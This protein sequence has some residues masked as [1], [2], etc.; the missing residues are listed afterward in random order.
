MTRFLCF[1][2]TWL[3]S[4]SF[5]STAQTLRDDFSGYAAGSDSA[6]AWDAQSVGWEISDGACIG[7]SGVSVW[8]AAPFASA[9]TFT[10]DVTVLEQLKGDWLVAGIGLQA[11]E[12]NYWA[13]NLVAA[14]E[15]KQRRHTAELNESHAG[16]WLAAGTGNTRLPSLPGKGG[17]DWQLNQT[18]RFEISLTADAITAR[19][20]QGADELARFGFKLPA[21]T[22]AVRAGRPM[23]RASGLRVRFDNATVTVQQTAPEPK[24]ESRKF[25]AWVSR[26]GKPAVK[27]T[28]FFRTALIGNDGR[29]LSSNYQSPI[30]NDRSARWWLV[31]PE[32]KPFFDVGTDHVNYRAH[33]CEALGYAPYHRNVAAKFGSE[34]AWAVSAIE[35]LKTWGFNTLPAGHSP[36]LRHRGL[37]HILFAS[38]GASFAK[39]EWI[40]EPIHWTG[41]PDVFSRH[42]PTHCRLVARK[43]AQESRGDSWCLGTFLDNELEWY[44]KKGHLVDE[45]FKLAPTAPAKRA[46]LDWLLKRWGNLAEINHRLGTSCADEKAFLAAMT[47]PKSSDALTEVHDGFL[48]EIAERYFG[49]AAKAM[50]EADP[51]HLVLGCRFAGRAPEQTLG[52]AGK[53]ND[54]FTF[55]TYPRVDFENV[56]RPDGTGGAVHRV[57]RE[58]T[59]MYRVV[60]KPMIITEWSFPAL[61]SG[62]PCKHGAGMRVDTQEQKAACYRI[63]ANA[64]TDLPFMVG[65]H[66]FMWVDEPALGIASTFPE[67]SNYGLVNEKDETYETLVKTATE[68]NR[69]AAARHARSIFSGDLELRAAKNAVELVNTN[70]IAARGTLRLTAAG[71]SRIEEVTLKPKS[72]RRFPIGGPRPPGAVA[73]AKAKGSRPEVAIHLANAWCAE[74]QQWDGTKTRLVGGK[75]LGPLDIAN[76]SAAT[77]DGVPVVLDGPPVVAAMLA[78]LEP[79]RTLTMTAPTATFAETERLELKTDGTTWL[80]ERKDGSLFDGIR[81]GGLPMGRLVFAAHQKIDGH[82]YWTAANRMASLRVQE[83]TDAWIV[84]AVVEFGSGAAARGPASFRAG[85]RAAVF[86]RGGLALVKP[87]WVENSDSRSWQLADVFW[88]CRSAIGGTPDDDIIGGP[89]APNYY[90]ASQFI[91]DGK[92]GGCF[93]AVSQPDGW[94]VAFWKDSSI[95]PDVYRKVDCE[96]RA[97]QRHECG[98]MPYVWVYAFRDANGWRDVARRSQQTAQGLLTVESAKAKPAAEP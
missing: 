33:W 44:G 61:D 46:L 5:E 80:C 93:G 90:R 81:A 97:G 51:D 64:M 50:R 45:I 58:L 66:Y 38:F 10:C 60:R 23:L 14:P 83:Q 32:G 85:L 86:K 39:R 79:G 94:R 53:Y 1:V 49:V 40:A 71:K 88:F 31:D 67:D 17:F 77:L 75:T 89:A 4:S 54:V 26:K 82:D 59:E 56:W 34:D 43:M 16:H 12:K 52:A 7:D 18:Y 29:E 30:T 70:A 74:L 27:A 98:D 72:V 57:P 84:E 42:W 24:S 92:L 62:L 69:S 48:A 6:P 21:S 37:P 19:I 96:L 15:A 73:D 9:V 76:A 41:F 68:V 95:H 22:P 47:V 13:V 11:D 20:T 2:L 65:Q 8:R 3:L 87:L 36:S 91:T 28:G 35:R 78:Q 25:P 55:N 63:F